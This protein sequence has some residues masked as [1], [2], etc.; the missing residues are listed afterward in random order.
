MRAKVF[1]MVDGKR[2]MFRFLYVEFIRRDYIVTWDKSG[3]ITGFGKFEKKVH[4]NYF[5]VLEGE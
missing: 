3:K 2:F 1:E 5:L 4:R